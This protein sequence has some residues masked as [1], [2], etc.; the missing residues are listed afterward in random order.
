MPHSAK[1]FAERLNQ[2][3]SETGAPQSVRERTSILNRVLDISKHQA[4]NLLEGQ[5]FPDPDLLQ[6]IA[7]E[8]EVDV[9]WLSGE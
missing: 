2:C 5:Q 8:F 1:H 4:W 9:R 6:K 3:L 7:E